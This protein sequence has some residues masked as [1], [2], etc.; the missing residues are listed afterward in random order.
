VQIAHGATRP[1]DRPITE[2]PS[3]AIIPDPLH[4]V[5]YSCHG[6]RRCT[7]CRTCHLHTT[8]QANVV[9]QRNKDKRKTKQTILDSNS[10]FIKSMTHHNQTKKL[11]TWF[12][13][14]SNYQNILAIFY[15]S[16]SLSDK[17]VIHGISIK[18]GKI[19]V[20]IDGT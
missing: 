1:L 9:L 5:S 10:N 4:Q 15:L 18:L 11:T 20:G 2:Y 19:S 7:T 14:F 3:C 17:S 13:I 16:S 8:R 12:L 6:P